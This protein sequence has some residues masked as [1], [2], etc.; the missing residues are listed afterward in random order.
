MLC[1][2]VPSAARS[3]VMLCRFAASG[4][5][6]LPDVNADSAFIDAGRS[7][8]EKNGELSQI[9]AHAA[10]KGAARRIGIRFVENIRDWKWRAERRNLPMFPKYLQ[11]NRASNLPLS[12][13]LNF[14]IFMATP[15]TQGG[16]HFTTISILAAPASGLK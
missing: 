13:R 7:R 2:V 4:H 10:G 9:D 14:V 6:N 15:A 11:M 12:V 3:P 8:D 16:A 5:E 1:Q